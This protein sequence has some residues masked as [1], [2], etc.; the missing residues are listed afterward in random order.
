VRGSSGAGKHWIPYSIY[1][2]ASMQCGFL[3]DERLED[4]RTDAIGI[5][6]E[7]SAGDGVDIVFFGHA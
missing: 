6:P 1:G 5:E 3:P 7:K 4:L 2:R